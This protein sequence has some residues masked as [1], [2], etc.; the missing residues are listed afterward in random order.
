MRVL[1][2]SK[3]I[4]ANV[5]LFGKTPTRMAEALWVTFQPTFGGPWM[6]DKLGELVDVSDVV[7]N[8]SK[9]IHVVFLVI[10]T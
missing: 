10:I 6:A 8:G 2:N 3:Y 5:Q 1:Q 7:L 9:H 4:T